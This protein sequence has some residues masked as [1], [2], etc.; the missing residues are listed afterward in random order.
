MKVYSIK[1][2]AENSLDETIVASQYAKEYGLNLTIIKISFNDYLSVVE[3]LIKNKN[4]PLH[5]IEPALYLAAQKI[6]SDGFDNIITGFNA[7]IKFGGLDLLLAKNWEIDEFIKRFSFVDSKKVLENYID[8]KFVFK[9]YLKGKNIDTILFLKE[10]YGYDTSLAFLNSIRSA[11]CDL[12]APYS[13]LKLKNKLDIGRI[14]NGES[15]YHLKEVFKKRYKNF[16]IPKKISFARPLDQW[17]YK[18]DGPKR[19]EFKQNIN[20]S[21]FNGNQKWL[22]YC[23]EY[24]LNFND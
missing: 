4:S 8:M 18:W 5:P 3:K 15:K 22:I 20:I 9:K 1:F 2:E 10:V 24:F 6:K 21:E 14:R 13:Y 17:L 16:N 19:N 11:D 12:V 23:L 7:D